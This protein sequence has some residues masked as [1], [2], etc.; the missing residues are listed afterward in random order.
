MNLSQL[1]NTTL[2]TII[3]DLLDDSSD[4]NMLISVIGHLDNNSQDYYFRLDNWGK[5]GTNGKIDCIKFVRSC[6]GLGLKEAREAVEQGGTI[7]L[8]QAQAKEF[9][10][11]LAHM[12]D[13]TL[14][15]C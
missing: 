3:D 12:V 2:R 11:T 7:T 4:K 8:T 1:S 5:D 13:Y 10:T 15:S 14:I 6:T 9:E